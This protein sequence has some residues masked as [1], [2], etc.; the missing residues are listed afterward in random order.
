MPTLP[1]LF[2]GRI[3][4]VSVSRF[5]YQLDNYFGIVE[6]NDDVKMSQIAIMLLEGTAYN[7]FAV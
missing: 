2:T 6:F 1:L 3:N 7:W 4:V 5:V